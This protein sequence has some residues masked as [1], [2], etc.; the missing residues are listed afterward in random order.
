MTIA[1]AADWVT[2]PDGK[3]TAFKEYYA[4]NLDPARFIIQKTVDAP[5]DPA[6]PED[7]A[8][9]MLVRQYP[10]FVSDTADYDLDL[11]WT[12]YFSVSLTAID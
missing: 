9:F 11:F 7:A 4:T 12:E 3:R 1:E 10:A 2:I 5:M 8:I 6:L